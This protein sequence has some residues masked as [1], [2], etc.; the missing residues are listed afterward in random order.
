MT[1][2]V[3][4]PNFNH[5][6]YL[7]ECLDAVIAQSLQPEKILVLDDCS[8]D[9]SFEIISRY[10][11]KHKH[12]VLRRN[13]ARLG[14]IASVNKGIQD[15]TTDYLCIC[16][17]D[18][19]VQ[20][21]FFASS[22]KIFKL[23]PHVALCVGN[24]IHFGEG[25]KRLE[26]P[27]IEEE[28]KILTPDV[29]KSVL[30]TS[31][32]KLLSHS[33]MYKTSIFKKFGGL[34]PELFHLCDWFLNYQIGFNNSIAVVPEIWSAIRVLDDSFGRSSHKNKRQRKKAYNQLLKKIA[35]ECLVEEFMSSGVL[36]QIGVK[37]VVYLA[38]NPRFWRYLPM[39]FVRK[40]HIQIAK[41]F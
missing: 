1:F 10:Q 23:H 14:V 33:S 28:V 3:V 36:G 22:M 11:K 31:N 29:L 16:A 5:A 13:E 34:D 39:S 7:S 21:N 38:V 30:R 4:I 41:M 37:M 6:K 27:F 15:L 8:T 35:N 24:S 25:G 12:I 32:F 18:D 26:S 19:L 9:G 17:A 2:T 40:F 20:N